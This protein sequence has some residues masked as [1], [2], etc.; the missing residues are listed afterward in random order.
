MNGI[1][2]IVRAIASRHIIITSCKR[3]EAASSGT[4][5]FVV[6]VMSSLYRD[7]RAVSNAG[8]K[9]KYISIK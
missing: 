4:T 2:E 5:V 7:P 8:R 6:T 9:I 1:N 3:H